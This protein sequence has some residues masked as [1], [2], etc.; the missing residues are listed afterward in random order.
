M[1]SSLICGI[2]AFSRDS[3]GILDKLHLRLTGCYR[4]PDSWK[5]YIELE[6]MCQREDSCSQKSISVSHAVCP[7]A[8]STRNASYWRCLLGVCVC[9]CLCV[10]VCVCVCSLLLKSPVFQ[11]LKFGN[12]ASRENEMECSLFHWYTSV[13]ALHFNNNKKVC[14]WW[15]FGTADV[16]LIFFFLLVNELSQ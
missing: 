9:T 8:E 1:S 11:I 12:M 5:W 3:F 16:I 10:C 15:K 2:E 14:V 4:K 13:F 6:K 7:L